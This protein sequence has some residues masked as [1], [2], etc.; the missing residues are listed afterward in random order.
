MQEPAG[1]RARFGY[2][3][4]WLR[5]L[6]FLLLGRCGIDLMDTPDLPSVTDFH[7]EQSRSRS[8]ARRFLGSIARL[9]CIAIYIYLHKSSTVSTINSTPLLLIIYHYIHVKA[10]SR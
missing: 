7:Y 8:I 10:I 2:W 9:V 6:D 3:V 1:F 5:F 4:G